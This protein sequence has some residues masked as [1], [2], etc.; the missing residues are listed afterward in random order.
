MR[1]EHS[2]ESSRNE[3][4]GV[5]GEEE[6]GGGIRDLG[7]IEWGRGATCDSHLEEI[8]VPCS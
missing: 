6:E 1:T 4:G 5:G 7:C 2:F 3:K 8:S